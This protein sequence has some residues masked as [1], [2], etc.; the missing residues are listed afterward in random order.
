MDMYLCTEG[1]RQG[2]W[3]CT[4]S[5]RVLLDTAAAGQHNILWPLLRG[6][7]SLAPTCSS[8]AL[9]APDHL[10]R[11]PPS[12]GVHLHAARPPW[13]CGRLPCRVASEGHPLGR[14]SAG[15]RSSC[16]RAEG[17]QCDS[18]AAERRSTSS[19]RRHDIRSKA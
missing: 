3:G 18:L 8:V 2:G 7:I 9:R 14:V 6:S 19:A 13:S 5:E 16:A 17:A 15:G 11:T 4:A 1:S 12:A 10:Q